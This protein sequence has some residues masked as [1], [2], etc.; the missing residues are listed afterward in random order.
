MA[1]L[2]KQ[3][4]VIRHQ[5]V[6][7]YKPTVDFRRATP[8]FR[9]EIKRD[10]RREDTSALMGNSREKDQGM[11]CER[12]YVGE[13]ASRFHVGTRTTLGSMNDQIL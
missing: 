9:E 13:M 6:V 8:N 4:N 12:G 2:G 11:A 3:M 5:Q 1:A 7:A 10:L